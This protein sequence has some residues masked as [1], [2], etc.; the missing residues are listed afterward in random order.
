MEQACCR[1]VDEHDL[2]CCSYREN[3][4]ILCHTLFKK[5]VVLA[6]EQYT[7]RAVST[8]P[9]DRF[10]EASA[11]IPPANASCGPPDWERSLSTRFTT[12]D[13]TFAASAAAPHPSTCR[14]C[15]RV[16]PRAPAAASAS[17]AWTAEG[18]TAAFPVA[19]AARTRPASGTQKARCEAA[20][21][22]THGRVGI[23][24][25]GASLGGGD[26]AAD[27][28]EKGRE[29]IPAVKGKG[30]TRGCR[31]WRA[32]RREESC[33]LPCSFARSVPASPLA[34]LP[35]VLEVFPQ[36]TVCGL[37]FNWGRMGQSRFTT[38]AESYLMLWAGRLPS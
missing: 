37:S 1:A 20:S 15:L 17:E 4:A 19:E 9:G 29:I 11:H 8:N 30:M 16:A 22:S 5:S 35:R 31:G 7:L 13:A 10:V 36:V 21:A 12:R 27:A 3:C 25:G 6:T 14:S 26:G 32:R 38:W 24:G 23:G 28:E 18:A 2:P 34:V 33:I